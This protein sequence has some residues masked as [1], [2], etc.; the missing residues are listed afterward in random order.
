MF[1]NE[2]LRECFHPHAKRDFF[3]RTIPFI[4]ACLLLL[5]PSQSAL[6]GW[7]DSQTGQP[8]QVEPYRDPIKDLRNYDYASGHAAYHGHNLFWDSTCGTWR[9]SATGGEIQV[10]PYRDPINDVRNYDFASGHA[11]YHGHNLHWMPCPPPEQPNQ[12]AQAPQASTQVGLL[13]E[14]NVV[15]TFAFDSTVWCLFHPSF[16]FTV[17]LMPAGTPTLPASPGTGFHGPASPAPASGAT[18]STGAIPPVNH[19]FLLSSVAPGFQGYMIAQSPFSYSHGFGALTTDLK[20]DDGTPVPYAPPFT[21][22]PGG[23]TTTDSKTAQQQSTNP[24]TPPPVYFNVKASTTSIATGQT[25]TQLPGESIKFLP[26][27]TVNPGLP[28]TNIAQKDTETGHGS[29][30]VQGVV[31]PSQGASL[32]AWQTDLRPQ[33]TKQWNL[34]VE[35]QL[36]NAFSL[37]VNLGPPV[38]GVIQNGP[39]T[40]PWS[41]PSQSVDINGTLYQPGWLPAGTA[42]SMTISSDSPIELNWCWTHLPYA[43]GRAVTKT[44][45]H[46]ALP[47]ARL[48]TAALFH[49]HGGTL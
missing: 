10:E 14:S 21:I 13:R 27:W 20:K 12:N 16:P 22:T 6:A 43:P 2:H 38:T 9:D 11:N 34:F 28:D 42:Q 40:V 36:G 15:A 26:Q 30:P 3:T 17:P 33:L 8:I 39:G 49:R 44:D 1:R 23:G 5:G 46:N 35:R 45:P 48:H 37:D 31:T 25:A 24:N 19:A 4:A 18:P 32:S 7:I 41:G 29:D 47:G